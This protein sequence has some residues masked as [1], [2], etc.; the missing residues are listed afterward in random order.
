[1]A[2]R[3]PGAPE[4]MRFRA[5][6]KLRNPNQAPPPKAPPPKTLK[7]DFKGTSLDVEPQYAENSL[8]NLSTK[9]RLN[10][11]ARYQPFTPFTTL[12]SAHFIVDMMEKCELKA[13]K[14]SK[15]KKEYFA[16]FF[17]NIFAVFPET[18]ISIGDDGKEYVGALLKSQL[19]SVINYI[20]KRLKPLKTF[21]LLNKHEDY[22]KIISTI[23]KRKYYCVQEFSNDIQK[24]LFALKASADVKISK[25]A[26]KM[27]IQ[28]AIYFDPVFQ[29]IGYCCSG[30]AEE[31]QEDV[32]ECKICWANFHGRCENYY[33]PIDGKLFY[34]RQCKELNGINLEPKH[35]F[36]DI[37]QNVIT[38]AMEE[39]IKDLLASKGINIEPVH[40]RML[41]NQDE[42]FEVHPSLIQ[43]FQYPETLEYRKKIFLA[44]Q[45]VENSETLFFYFEVHEHDDSSLP[46]P[47]N[48]R[49]VYLA[50][51]D[52]VPYFKPGNNKEL[53]N[54]IYNEIIQTYLKHAKKMGF[55]KANFWLSHA[56]KTKRFAFIG[57]PD[58]DIFSNIA[59]LRKFY[60]KMLD[61]A[62]EKN[63]IQEYEFIEKIDP[64]KSRGNSANLK[65]QY[66]PYL[67]EDFW[68]MEIPKFWKKYVENKSKKKPSF[69]NQLGKDAKYALKNP[70]NKET[71]IFAFLFS[72]DDYDT[73]FG[74]E[75]DEK[76]PGVQW[77]LVDDRENFL[78]FQ[79]NNNL[80][81][82][83]IE[84]AQYASKRLLSEMF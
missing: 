80:T 15:S 82:D 44:F 48:L 49:V 57:H 21:N 64:F 6:Q 34:C 31:E 42:T 41:C 69:S 61:R 35:S 10:A 59:S 28:Y 62:I 22:K 18:D 58:S 66:I 74:V 39:N 65:M 40:V 5:S 70:A 12:K 75:R 3:D 25:A 14:S 47:T 60:I 30:K 63:I 54:E 32:F 11:L 1:M 17:K 78:E 26:E 36:K 68:Y 43:H 73:V 46:L 52:F 51:L 27:L 56:R 4:I 77:E 71:V 29:E 53:C 83:T 16:K 19:N 81:F 72:Y 50:C 9:E 38:E 84:N 55:I 20:I 13:Y 45:K 37:V 7:I 33:E 24:I 2:G 23:K 8:F 76:A 67:Y 79:R